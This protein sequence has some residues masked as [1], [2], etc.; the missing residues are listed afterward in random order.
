MKNSVYLRSDL[1]FLFIMPTIKFIPKVMAGSHSTSVN[2]GQYYAKPVL[3]SVINAD[4]LNDLIAQDSQVERAEVA[5][6][7]DAICKQIKE[8]VCNGHSIQVGTLGTFSIGFNAAVQTSEAAVSGRDVRRVNVR[9]YESKYIK[10]ELK[11][12]RFQ[13]LMP[14]KTE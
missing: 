2:K 5:Q 8:L 7:T 6:V 3:A 9:L 13:N 14:S 1:N 10:N 11:A 12:T 4:D